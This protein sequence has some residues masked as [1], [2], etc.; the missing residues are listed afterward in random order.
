MVTMG[1]YALALAF[2]ALGTGGA[3]SL[4]GHWRPHSSRPRL[5]RVSGIV[6]VLS[7]CGLLVLVTLANKGDKPWSNIP[8]YLASFIPLP[9]PPYID[10]PDY[11]HYLRIPFPK[12]VYLQPTDSRLLAKLDRDIAEHSKLLH[13]IPRSYLVFDGPT[14]F[15]PKEINGPQADF[16]VGNQLYFDYY[17]STPTTNPN[18]ITIDAVSGWVYVEPDR[19]TETQHAIILD[20]NERV[21]QANIKDSRKPKNVGVFLPGEGHWNSLSATHDG[22]N[23]W[24]LT[25]DDLDAMR[26]GNEIVFIVIDMVYTDNGHIHHL[27]RCEFLQPPAKAPGIWHACDV[28]FTSD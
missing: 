12:G 7:L 18:P 25:Q 23:P 26:L 20:F 11:D 6:L 17:Y 22:H 1:E 21:Q 27:R 28:T 8:T 19:K 14:R 3:L 2:L 13:F 5:L 4:T 15:P 10:E 9:A 24:I 16:S